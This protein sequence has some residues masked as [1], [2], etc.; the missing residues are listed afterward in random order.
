MPVASVQEQR[1]TARQLDGRELIYPGDE[2]LPEPEVYYNPHNPRLRFKVYKDPEFMIDPRRQR[3]FAPERFINGRFIAYTKV[4]RDGVR[5]VLGPQADR[6][7]GDNEK[8]QYRCPRE[9]CQFCTR[10]Y[11]AWEDHARYTE[12]FVTG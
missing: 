10:N 12:H 1:E 5:R 7:K 4:Q 11:E 2:L 6:W 8:R 9:S 3:N